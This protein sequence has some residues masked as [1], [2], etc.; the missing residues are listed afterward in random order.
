M[1]TAGNKDRNV[2]DLVDGTSKIRGALTRLK[3]FLRL[4]SKVKYLEPVGSEVSTAINELLGA[5]LALK[6]VV[7]SGNEWVRGRS[8]AYSNDAEQ[9]YSDV[10]QAIVSAWD[11]VFLGQREAQM[12][13]RY[14]EFL[15]DPGAVEKIV[16][17]MEKLKYKLGGMKR[18]F[19][20]VDLVEVN[21]D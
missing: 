19:N 5:E 12:L 17:E 15:S 18:E 7:D 1:K 14:R 3:D 16:R 21:E 11:D 20:K 2:E 4:G 6:R 9:M 13:A 8:A 10:E